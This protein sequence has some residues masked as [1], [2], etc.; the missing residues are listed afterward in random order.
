MPNFVIF[1][2]EST[3]GK[4]IPNGESEIIEI[5]AVKYNDRL[6][7]IGEFQAFIKPILHP[8]ITYFC[9]ELTSIT[10]TDVDNAETFDVVF[11]KF[12]DWATDVKRKGLTWT[13]EQVRFCSWGFYDRNMILADLKKNKH[14][15]EIFADGIEGYHISIKHQHGA[16]I[17]NKRGVGMAKA[18][19]M[20]G[21]PLEG[22]H[23]R[24]I[25]DARNIGKIF[26]QIFPQL[27]F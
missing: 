8:T 24:G 3:C 16:M 23:H 7:K 25:D 17:G 9:Q 14:M 18:L 10:Q 15:Y 4:E 5:G 27:K 21:I 12:Y 26:E 22:T 6:E 2:L 13:A 11:P 19:E 1:D 20:L